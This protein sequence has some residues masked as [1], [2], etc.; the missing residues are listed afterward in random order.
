MGISRTEAA[1][2]LTDIESTT[3]RSHQMRGYRVAGP[4]LMAWGAIWIVG[5][6]AMGLLPAEH[7]SLV[8]LPLDIL[9]VLATLL[10][11]RRGRSAQNAGRGAGQSGLGWRSAAGA[12]T[13]MVF[14]GV[15]FTLFRPVSSSVALVYPGVLCGLIYV[16]LGVWRMPRFMWIGAAMAAASLIGYALF[17]PWLAFWMAGV[18]GGGLMLGGF[19][20]RRA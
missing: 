14:A 17:Q 1:A 16:T 18:G 12:L 11:A 5:Y 8:W 2:A 15:T 9:G 10:L 3:G 4:I 7:I 6:L 20:M 13:V 19:W